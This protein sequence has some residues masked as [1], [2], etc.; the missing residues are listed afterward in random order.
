MAFEAQH[1]G[2]QSALCIK[3]KIKWTFNDDEDD[4]DD[5]DGGERKLEYFRVIASSCK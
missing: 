5:D 1:R 3:V 4:D 2:G